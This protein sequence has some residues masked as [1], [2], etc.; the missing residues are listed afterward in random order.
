M[1]HFCGTDIAHI[2]RKF[3]GP[4][5]PT[6]EEFASS[7]NNHF[8]YIV[9]TKILLNSNIVLQQWM[10]KSSTSLSSAYSVLCPQMAERS[11]ATSLPLQSHVKVEVE[12]DDTRYTY[13]IFFIYPLI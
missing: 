2:Y 13:D 11:I 7:L 4:L 8:P 9:D 6:A 5:P 12:V 3:F 10:R 1:F